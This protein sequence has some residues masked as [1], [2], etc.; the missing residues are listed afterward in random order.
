MYRYGV[1]VNDFRIATITYVSDLDGNCPYDTY[2]SFA[3]AV[4]FH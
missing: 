4:Q 3:G 2:S 1:E